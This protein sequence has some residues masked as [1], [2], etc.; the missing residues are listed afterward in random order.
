MEV[1]R[2][3]E[4]RNGPVRHGLLRGLIV[5]GLAPVALLP[6]ALAT[7]Q[8]R[9]PSRKQRPPIDVVAPP[10]LSIDPRPALGASSNA[11]LAA[12]FEADQ[13]ERK[14]LS[15]AAT[16]ADW[17]ALTAKDER[18]RARVAVIV[19]AGGATTATDWYAAAMIYQHGQTLDDFAHAREYAVEA[20]RRGDEHGRWLAAAAWD[21][22][23]VHAGY[24]QRFGTQSICDLT[25]GG[26]SRC[27]LYDYDPSIT[28]EERARWNV[29]SLATAL[30]RLEP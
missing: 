24:P 26:L 25:D 15:A 23:L 19:S 17:A 27:R 11:E 13:G 12:L 30:H 8:G 1:M 18:R 22:W 29:P 16:P 3:R 20:V 10:P 14:G 7:G 5:A 2:P 4:W 6:I 21:R 9:A 28:D